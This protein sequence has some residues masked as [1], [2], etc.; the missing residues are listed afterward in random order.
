MMLIG[1]FKLH[2][3]FTAFCALQLTS[4]NG[5]SSCSHSFQS[6]GKKFS[7]LGYTFTVRKKI[8]G[9]NTNDSKATLMKIGCAISLCHCI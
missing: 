3:I 4:V 1:L 2:S 9:A 6:T 8:T 5:K 7:N